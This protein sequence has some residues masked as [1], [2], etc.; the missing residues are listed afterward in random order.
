MDTKEENKIPISNL[1]NFLQGNSNQDEDEKL[2]N[3]INNSFQC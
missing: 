3:W 2:L 1:V